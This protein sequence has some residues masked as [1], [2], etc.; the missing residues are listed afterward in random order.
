MD[1][2][3]GQL[4]ER[5][6]IESRTTTLDGFGQNV[7]AWTALATVWAQALPLRGREFFSAAQVQ[8]ERSVKFTLRYRPDIVPTMRLVWRGQPHDITGVIDL[9]GQREWLEVIALAGVKDGA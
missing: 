9:G 7:A 4:R 2:D 3:P 5:V 1:I 8:Q 6:T